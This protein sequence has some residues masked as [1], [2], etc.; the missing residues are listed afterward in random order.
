MKI[1]VNGEA[2]EIRAGTLA[3]ALHEL[4]YGGARIATAV[5]ETFVP[6][7]LREGRELSPGDRLEILAPRQGG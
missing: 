2:A 1:T 4:G 3:A 6:A 5:N 7:A